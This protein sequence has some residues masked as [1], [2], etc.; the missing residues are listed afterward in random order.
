MT[1]T[2]FFKIAFS[3]AI[4]LTACQ[5]E[6]DI[7]PL[8]ET[9]YPTVYG[10][11]TQVEWKTRFT[12]FEKINN[13]YNLT[14]DKLGFAA[15]KINLNDSNLFSEEVIL[16]TVDLIVN[17]YRD[18]LGIEKGKTF[19]L[20][21]EL[22]IDDPFLIPYGQITIEDLFDDSR[23][24]MFEEYRKF[25]YPQ[26]RVQLR[27]QQINENYFTG[28]N[29]YF[30]FDI[31]E[32]TLWLNGH[33]FPEASIPKN[34]IYTSK[35]AAIIAWH[36]IKQLTGQDTR[37]TI[38]NENPYKM[39]ICNFIDDKIEIRECW[40]FTLWNLQY[41]LYIDTQTGEVVRSEKYSKYI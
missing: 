35:E 10:E 24:E 25:Y 30:E 6:E 11:L 21:R 28:S 29:L 12:E 39:L 34:E 31:K 19:N 2:N 41:R 13:P 1:T 15:G 5:K 7:K 27:Q 26:F 14:L 3:L 23:K 22:L 40:V 8:P 9:G 33:W 17:T 16:V 36:E 20:N 38:F 4:F 18:F 37:E 32:K